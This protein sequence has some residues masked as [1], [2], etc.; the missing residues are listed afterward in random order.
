M[1]Q[2]KKVWKSRS[3]IC[4]LVVSLRISDCSARTPW[5]TAPDEARLAA[6]V[7]GKDQLPAEGLVHYS[8]YSP[9]NPHYPQLYSSL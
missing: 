8:T 4:P 3:E 2:A 6:P 5:F 1:E 9:A 7:G